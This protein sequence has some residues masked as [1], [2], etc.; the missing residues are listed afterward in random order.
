MVS[1]LTGYAGVG[2][3]TAET[4]V[5]AFGPDTLRVLDEEPER[6]REVLPDRRAERV[7]QA[8]R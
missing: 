7:L 1:Q 3:K 5:E 6:V 8:R 4:L 2:Q